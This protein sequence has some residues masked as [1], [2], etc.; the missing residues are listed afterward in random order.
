MN[1]SVRSSNIRGGDSAPPALCNSGP[2]P[3]EVYRTPAIGQTL[4]LDFK[5][6]CRSK[7]LP[8][9]LWPSA[10]RELRPSQPSSAGIHVSPVRANAIATFLLATL[11]TEPASR[12]ARAMCARA[13]LGGGRRANAATS[14]YAT[15]A[16]LAERLCELGWLTT[17]NGLATTVVQDELSHAERIRRAR[18][19]VLPWLPR[20]EEYGVIRLAWC[21][22]AVSY[23]SPPLI[24]WSRTPSLVW[25]RDDHVINLQWLGG[26][27]VLTSA[28]RGA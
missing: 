13:M 28:E 4:Q 10:G 11:S 21:I 8:R 3:R 15:I 12:R 6:L 22:C 23:L 2:T 20:G 26:N 7:E 16:S 14:V 17:F 25:W 5:I 9:F 1:S 27:N 18:G 24:L 19:I